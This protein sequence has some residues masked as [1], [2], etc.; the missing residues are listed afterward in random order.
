MNFCFGEDGVDVFSLLLPLPATK[1]M[2]IKYKYLDI[3]I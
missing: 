1:T 2:D 3:Y